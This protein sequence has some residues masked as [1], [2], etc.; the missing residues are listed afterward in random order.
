MH[1]TN[2]K[3]FFIVLALC[4]ILALALS[5]LT[6]VSKTYPKTTQ[7]VE[8]DKAHDIIILEDY[9]GFLW[10]WGGCEDWQIGD[11]ASLIM[12]DNGTPI[13]YD[14]EIVS[15]RYGGAFENWR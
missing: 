12:E 9:N 1:H 15:I 5:V 13:I 8:I 3:P 11:I 14:D 7:V 4:M 6:P 2:I 10:E